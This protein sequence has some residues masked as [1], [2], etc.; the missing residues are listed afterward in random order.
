M[1]QMVGLKDPPMKEEAIEVLEMK[2]VEIE[3]FAMMVEIEVRE[4]KEFQ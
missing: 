1:K 2:E 3:V 4:E